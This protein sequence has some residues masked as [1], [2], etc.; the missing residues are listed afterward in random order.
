[1]KIFT[2]CVWERNFDGEICF[3]FVCVF[4]C[5]QI[6]FPDCYTN[7]CCSHP[8]YDIE[9][10]RDEINSMGIRKA[11]QRRLNY[12]LG[13][14][15]NQVNMNISQSGDDQKFLLFHYFAL[16]LTNTHSSHINVYIIFALLC[17][18]VC[19]VSWILLRALCVVFR[20]GQRISII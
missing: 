16:I 13:I 3:L 20:R 17:V 6:T 10:E 11:A 18:C 9:C 15:F 7:A 8:L 5:I 4:V 14:P 12:E 19:V 1:M 2:E